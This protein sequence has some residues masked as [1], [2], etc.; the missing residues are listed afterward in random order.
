ML[1]WITQRRPW[2]ANHHGFIIETYKDL[3][4]ISMLSRIYFDVS[5]HG[6]L[7]LMHCYN[8]GK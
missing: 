2:C 3:Y 5:R 6:A 7:L 4:L 8:V 1:T